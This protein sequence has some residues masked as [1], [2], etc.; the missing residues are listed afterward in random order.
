MSK[1]IKCRIALAV[2]PTGEWN[3]CGWGGNSRDIPDSQKMELACDTLNSGESRYW[4]EVEVG[5]P[6]ANL[7]DATV[8]EDKSND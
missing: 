4:I 8:T 1:K 7:V 2:D 3:C 5:V 6:E